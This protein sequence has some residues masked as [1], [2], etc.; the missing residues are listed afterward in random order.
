VQVPTALRPRGSGE[1]KLDLRVA[2]DLVALVVEKRTGGL[3][4]ARFVLFAGVGLSGMVVNLAVL[5]VAHALGARSFALSAGAATVVA[6][7]WN[8][9]LNNVLTFRERRLRGTAFWRGL[10]MFCLA[11]ATGG[12]LAEAVGIGVLRL[13]P[14]W[15]VAGIAGALAGGVLNYLLASRLSWTKAQPAVGATTIFTRFA[16]ATRG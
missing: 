5:T 7:V 12:L 13:I 4:S 3:L 14:S 8:F 10:M 9:L 11:S 2:L 1:S 15:G 6:M 16:R